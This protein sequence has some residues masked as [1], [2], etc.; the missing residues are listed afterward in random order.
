MLC[1]ASVYSSPTVCLVVPTDGARAAE[2]GEEYHG[3]CDTR[4]GGKLYHVNSNSR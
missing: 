4:K 1:Q 2:P 3:V